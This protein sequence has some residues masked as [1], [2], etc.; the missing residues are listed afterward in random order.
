VQHILK[1][2]RVVEG[3]AFIAAPSG[4]MTLAQL[5]ADVIRF[6]QI[7][8]G[9]DY[10][11]WP[12]T[13]NGKSLY[14]HSLN[15]GK[16]SIAVNFRNEAG[17]ELIKNLI[18]AP[19]E[20]N[21]LFVTNFP[22]KGWLA[23]QTL[24]AA[25]EDL[26]YVNLV[27]DRHGGNALDYTVN[28]K[29]GLPFLSGDGESPV[30]NPFPAWDV[31]AGQQIAIALLAAER[32]RRLSG[33][34]QFVQLAL[35]DVALATM[36][37]LGYVAEAEVNQEARQPMGNHI[38]GTFGHDF[39]CKD[40]RRVMI[41]GVSPNQWNAIINVTNTK[42]QIISLEEELGLDFSKEGDR[43]KARER[44]K[45]LFAPWFADKLYL[46]VKQSLNMAG[47][48]WG[49]YQSIAELISDDVDCTEA[50]PLFSRI[51]QPGIGTYLVPSQAIQFTGLESEPPKPAPLLGQHTDEILTE[52]LGMGSGQ[53]SKLHDANIIAGPQ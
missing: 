32:H 49:P 53:I 4:G 19:G 50:N 38:F 17:R 28:S 36:G 29:I 7:G 43:F 41:V 14:W 24:R 3:S 11:R 44:L 8:G 10:R 37:H 18:A 22:A 33:A 35:A 12:V 52:V 25:R 9:I 23:D 31:L 40:G 20:D 1:G 13:E 45:D 21:G 48:C 26:I 30:N 42:P 51:E 34:G 5:G 15:K 39:S 46:E 2:L 16:R 27:G 6:D 47:V